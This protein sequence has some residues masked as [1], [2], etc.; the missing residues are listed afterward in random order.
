[1]FIIIVTWETGCSQC[2]PNDAS[3]LV[4]SQLIKKYNSCNAFLSLV[5]YSFST[6]NFYFHIKVKSHF[7][8]NSL[9]S[10]CGTLA[11]LCVYDMEAFGLQSLL[12]IYLF[13]IFNTET[14]PFIISRGGT[15]YFRIQYITFWGEAHIVEE[16]LPNSRGKL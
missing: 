2:Y 3:I 13:T 16:D 11:L 12:I 14:I 7:E 5:S 9:D 4:C 6:I 15:H 1:M 10:V 8:E